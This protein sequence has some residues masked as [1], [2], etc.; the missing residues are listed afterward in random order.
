MT[1][2]D[3]PGSRRRLP[4]RRVLWVTGAV[5]VA[6]A[7]GAALYLRGGSEDTATAETGP[8]TAIATVERRDL[9]ET[10]TLDGSLAFTGSR[11]V[12]HLDSSSSDTS[13][14]AAVTTSSPVR[15]STDT[16]V[17]I[18]YAVG[19]PDGETGPAGTTPADTTP[20]DTTPADTTPAETAPADTTP[21]ETGPTVTEPTETTPSIV[22]PAELGG[23]AQ[24]AGG[25]TGQ[26][27]ASGTSGSTGSTNG[28]GSPGIVTWLPEVGATIGRG[29]A[30][31]R[32]DGKPIVLMIGKLPAWRTLK[33][34]VSDG[35]DVRQLELNLV[36]LGYDPKEKIVVDEHFGPATKA[37]VERWQKDLGVSRTG[38]I[39]LGRAVFLPGQRR[40]SSLATQ[41]GA[42]LSV[43][44]TV[45]ETTSRRQVVTV[46]LET[47]KRSLVEVGDAVTVELPDGG[48]VAGEITGIGSVAT[49]STDEQTGDAQGAQAGTANASDAT[50]D[51][52]IRLTE[53]PAVELDL[54]PVDVEIRRDTRADVLAVP[55]AALLALAGGGY[56]IEVLDGAATRLVA[57]E[58]GLFADGYVEIE[59]DGVTE[60]MDVVV[61][62]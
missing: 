25:E 22:Q 46:A 48:E 3:E 37:A 14:A 16:A 59:G 51:V 10:E 44:A 50:I 12:I 60:G 35:P 9:V 13:S 39:R 11:A 31:Y 38:A 36:E 18:A 28:T 7:A 4:I 20:A 33:T 26:T 42:R 1:A 29:D 43:G 58:P 15:D 24:S 61:P 52:E 49:S 56:A 6:A 32:V 8:V 19:E 53:I 34:G 30:L 40:V 2:A 5:G 54:A 62:A 17:A 23:V 57:I 55:V 27:S 45:M 21:A 47:T 41:V